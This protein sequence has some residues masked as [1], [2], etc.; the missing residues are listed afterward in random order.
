MASQG[1]GFVVNY[2][3]EER[4][5]SVLYLLSTAAHV[6]APGLQ[7]IVLFPGASTP[8]AATVV[9]RN[10]QADLALLRIIEHGMDLVVPLNL[11]TQEN[12]LD[13]G[14]LSFASGYYPVGINHRWT[15]H[16]HGNNL[17]HGE[18]VSRVWVGTRH[19]NDP[20]TTIQRIRMKQWQDAPM[21][22][23]RL[24]LLR[25]LPWQEACRADR[26]WTQ[27]ESFWG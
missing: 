27:T 17:R 23:L 22:T 25:M 5:S 21:Q 12:V 9:G 1:S 3:E 2:F 20:M 11:G 6:A 8:P 16:D 24:W 15:G 26:W 19:S 10:V 13:V 7:R 4:G 18:W 14:T